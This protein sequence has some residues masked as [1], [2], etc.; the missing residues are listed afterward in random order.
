[1]SVLSAANA[2]RPRKPTQAKKLAG[3]F[4]AD[5]S[6]ADEPS[7]PPVQ[8]PAPPEHLPA[9]GKRI[10]AAWAKVLDPRR[11][12]TEADLPAL[13]QLVQVHAVIIEAYRALYDD[14]IDGHPRLVDEVTTKSGTSYQ[15]RAELRIIAQY[16]K[17]LAYWLTRFG[18]TPADKSR[19]SQ[20][21]APATEEDPLAEFCQ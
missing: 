18:L 19:A 12:V 16:D 20:L 11:V 7:S 21:A 8:I 14:A 4:R 9:P 2:G 13:E 3:T 1:M 15:P 5:R 17:L 6:N 10:W